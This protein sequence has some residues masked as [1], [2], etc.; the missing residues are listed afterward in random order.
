M[1]KLSQFQKL[2]RFGAQSQ[3]K[4]EYTV[5]LL[6]PAGVYQRATKWRKEFEA[7]QGVF[8]E[9][10]AMQLNN[11]DTWHCSNTFYFPA[12]PRRAENTMTVA[13]V[14]QIRPGRYVLEVIALCSFDGDYYPPL[15]LDV[16][17]KL[18]TTAF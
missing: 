9:M 10:V 12:D 8:F 7:P 5:S 17:L 14:Y 4:Q 13:Q 3:D 2:S 15:R 16:K 1:T 18:S 11:N 6:I